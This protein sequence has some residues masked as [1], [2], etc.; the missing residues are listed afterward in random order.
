MNFETIVAAITTTVRRYASLQ[1][2]SKGE[3]EITKQTRPYTD[4]GMDS[5]HDLNIT[6]EV[7]AILEVKL[8]RDLKLLAS[9]YRALSIEQAAR[10][11]AR[12]LNVELA[13]AS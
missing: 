2:N 10:V 6:C 4:L 7:E 1:S 9:E 13:I 8:D 5:L 3:V 12:E 11:V